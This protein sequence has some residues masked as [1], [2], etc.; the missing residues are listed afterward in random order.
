MNTRLRALYKEK[1]EKDE[2]AA[3]KAKRR[4]KA[5]D[6]GKGDEVSEDEVPEVIVSDDP[7]N[8]SVPVDKYAELEHWDFPVSLDNHDIYEFDEKEQSLYEIFGEYGTVARPKLNP[9]HDPKEPPPVEKVIVKPPT[10]NPPKEEGDEE[11]DGEEEKAEAPVVVEEPEEEVFIPPLDRFLY[12][13]FSTYKNAIL[14]KDDPI[15]LALM[16]KGE[17]DQFTL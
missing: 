5:L 12:Y 2:K 16:V 13:D 15:L 17:L 4:Q 11:D 6:D 3:I 14:K 10:P 7:F 9:A 1:T 8:K